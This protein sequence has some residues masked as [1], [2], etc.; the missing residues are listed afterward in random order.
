VQHRLREHAKEVNELL[1][2][3]AYF[4]V[5]GDAA[6]MAREVNTTLAQ[7]IAEQRGVPES[8]GEEVVKS[9]RSAN[10]YQVC[11]VSV[12]SPT[13]CQM[14]GPLAACCSREPFTSHDL[15]VQTAT[16]SFYE[17]PDT[18]HKIT[19]TIAGGCLVVKSHS[20]KTDQQASRETKKPTVLLT[21]W[22]RSRLWL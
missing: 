2:Q 12:V 6:N 7:I 17:E 19:N 16:A 20:S 13:V 15:A 9:M 5:C 1:Q 3:K 4:Y 8:K 21:Q 14:A 11:F 22:L 18:R 10:Q